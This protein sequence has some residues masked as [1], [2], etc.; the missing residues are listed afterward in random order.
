MGFFGVSGEECRKNTGRTGGTC[1]ED[2]LT[3]QVVLCILWM[4]GASYTRVK[5]IM[6]TNK[7]RMVKY[8]CNRKYKLL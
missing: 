5:D 1:G 4:T 8:G 6:M 2:A 3:G 7:Y